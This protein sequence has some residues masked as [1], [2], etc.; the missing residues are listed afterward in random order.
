MSTFRALL[1]RPGALRL[2]A[3]SGVGWWAFNGYG[4][5]LVLTIHHATGSFAVA[6][7]AT[8][9]FAAGSALLAP[10]RGRAVDRGGGPVLRGLAAAHLGAL[11][12]VVAA[13]ACLDRPPAALLLA[14]CLLAGATVPPLAA[15]ARRVWAQLAG[16]DLARSAHA[17]H[18]ALGETAGLASPVV[19]SVFASAVSPAVAL[20]VLLPGTAAAVA[21]VAGMTR[22]AP[23]ATA[24]A[25]PT[26]IPTPVE[27]STALT[28]PSAT[29]A[30]PG[31]TPAEPGVTDASAV[32]RRSLL[33]DSAG[34]RWLVA[35][36]VAWGLWL[37]AL[38]LTIPA[39]GVDAGPAPSAAADPTLVVGAPFVALALG[40]VLASVWTGSAR[41]VGSP[42][43]RYV[44]GSIVLAA[45]MPIAL[46][47]GGASVVLLVVACGGAGIGYGLVNVALFELL[48]HVTEAARATEAFTWITT[49]QA[50]GLA[51]GATAA[52]AL[53][54]TDPLRSLV[55]ASAAPLLGVAVAFAGRRSLT[56]AGSGSP[57]ATSHVASAGQ[58]QPRA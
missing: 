28:S 19:T 45:A 12:V 16:P 6:G 8:A 4:L 42:V 41:T 29:H 20:G 21:G 47:H 39:V 31:A 3:A 50:V 26:R 1:A 54:D 36:D 24:S 43:A 30:G 13:G 32:R 23:S 9:A 17:L 58:A 49:A 40:G 55:L 11:T 5:A 38:E 56:G 15:A 37:G 57:R 53:A 34:L 7:A 52:G 14:A 10:L 18:A 22:V 51:V 25:A 2:A 27:P 46:V 48:D 44:A 33:R 35:G